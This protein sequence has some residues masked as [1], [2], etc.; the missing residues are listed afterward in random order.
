MLA[1]SISLLYAGPMLSVVIEADENAEGLATTLAS[2]I[3]AAVD[4]VVREVIVCDAATK[5]AIAIV[6]DHAGCTYLPRSSARDGIRLARCEWLLFLEPGARLGD[7]W[8]D[9]LH[10][11]TTAD[12]VAMRFSCAPLSR[13]SWV[14]RWRQGRRPL[15]D[16]LVVRKGHALATGHLTANDIARS[17]RARRVEGVIFAAPR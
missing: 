8:A 15:R 13:L 5:D 17:T 4:G 3:P 12:S 9:A 2:L 7:G 16:G 14:E 6:A 11:P 10:T 1:P